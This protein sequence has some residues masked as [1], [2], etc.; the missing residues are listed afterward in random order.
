MAEIRNYT[1]NFGS[2]RPAAPPLTCAERK[3]AAAEIELRAPFAR[4]AS[5]EKG[6]P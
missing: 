2:G 5:V 1:L 3:L 6:T 4:A